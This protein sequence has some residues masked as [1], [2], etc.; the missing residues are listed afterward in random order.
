MAFALDYL[1]GV[2]T[3]SKQPDYKLSSLLPSAY[4]LLYRAEVD[5]S[6]PG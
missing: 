2:K 1:T 5:L 4:R 3:S 6:R